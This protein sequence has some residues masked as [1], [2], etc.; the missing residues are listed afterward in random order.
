MTDAGLRYG[1][2]SGTSNN[3]LYVHCIQATSVVREYLVCVL[4]SDDDQTVAR[5]V[6]PNLNNPCPISG[7]EIFGPYQ[8]ESVKVTR[9][10]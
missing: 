9:Y 6:T 8:E 4:V 5:G 7:T 3:L 10:K 1:V 2:P